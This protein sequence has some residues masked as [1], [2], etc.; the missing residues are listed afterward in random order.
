VIT[1]L[2]KM[3]HRLIGEDIELATRL[4][5]DLGTVKADPGQIEQVILNLSVN[6]RDAMP[7]GGK[8]LIET[9]NTVVGETYAS[10]N[11]AMLATPQVLLIISDT[12][13]GIEEAN[14]PHIFEPFFTT[15]NPGKGTGLGL[16]TVYGIVKQSGGSIQVET[17]IGKGTK[18]KILLPRIQEMETGKPAAGGETRVEM[19][20]GSETILVVEDQEMVR[21]LA[22]QIL[23][24]QGY[25]VLQ[26]ADGNTAISLC[27][28]YG[29]PIDLILTDVVMP[30]M[31]GRQ[32]IEKISPLH[33]NIKVLYMSGYSKDAVQ[34]SG[35]DS[36]IAFIHKPFS[37]AAL[38]YKVRE[39]LTR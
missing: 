3:L 39:A 33:P 8:L 16:A 17:E 25:Q 26:A 36:Q 27:Q 23:R 4:A 12:G 5:V 13:S 10:E 30:Q 28:E 38:A 14:L 19:P 31:S 35:L 2:M 1:D 18:F 20:K 32:M 29:D 37:S 34:Q 21:D 7:Y 11:A 24:M 22:C 6:A 15:K 9:R